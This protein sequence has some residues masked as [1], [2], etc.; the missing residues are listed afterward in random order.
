[1]SSAKA[2]N[3]LHPPAV[4]SAAGASTVKACEEDTLLDHVKQ[5]QKD[6]HRNR[7][8][9]KPE[10]NTFHDSLLSVLNAAS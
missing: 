2:G 3:V 8:P 5:V 4:K 10:N 6:N 1:M 9:Q 7:K